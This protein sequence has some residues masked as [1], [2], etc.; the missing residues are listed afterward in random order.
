ME[1][2]I[3]ILDSGVGGLRVMAALARQLPAEDIIYLGDTGRGPYGRGPMAEVRRW[4]EECAYFLL[5][6]GPKVLVVACHT[7][8]AVAGES[9]R[10]KFPV[11][12]FLAPG[13][14]CQRAAVETTTGVV[15]LLA[16]E[17]ALAVGFYQEA[18][19]EVALACCPATG[20]LEALEGR[21]PIRRPADEAALRAALERSLA[22]AC[23]AAARNGT[24]VEVVLL[25]EASLGGV[26]PLVEELLGAGV[27]VV[28]VAE[29][30]AGEVARTLATGPPAGG[31]PPGRTTRMS[32]KG[33]RYIF[34][35]GDVEHF[36]RW[37]PLL[38]G[39]PLGRVD[40]ASP[41][42]FFRQ[43]ATLPRG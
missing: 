33:G 37:G 12:V 1:K 10:E 32:G 18:L 25:G 24:E 36:R 30:L 41:E 31:R 5:R 14:L 22:P 23:D 40:V 9:L 8:G 39:G 13:L 3:A 29:A 28:E 20:L 42:R 2:P 34:V 11:P 19:G 43:M 26:G 15:A 6:F 4:A 21:A 27:R 17:T 35:S 16:S 38:Y 7:A